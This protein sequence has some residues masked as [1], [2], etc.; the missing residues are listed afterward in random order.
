MLDASQSMLGQWSGEQ[1]M[2]VATR[3]LSNLMDSLKKV[4]HL[5][6][7]LRIYGHQYS[8]ATG[9]RSC[10]DSKLEVPFKSNNYEAIKTKLK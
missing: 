9:N 6:V 2:V 8:V 3:L 10:E 7:A 4:E 1:K 5:E